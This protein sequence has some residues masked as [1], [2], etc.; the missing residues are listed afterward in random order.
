MPL[1]AWTLTVDDWRPGASAT[2]TAH[3]QRESTLDALAPWTRPPGRGGRLRHRPLLPHHGPPGRR[4]GP[5]TARRAARTGRRLRSR[6]PCASTA[7]TA[8]RRPAHPRAADLG[9]RLRPGTHT[10]E[11]EVATTLLNRLRVARPDV[12]GGAKR[13]DYGLT[14]PVRLVP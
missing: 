5:G 13:Q 14:G 4:L 3:E 6:S 8:A 11:I 7:T 2:E 10:I 1:T 9:A 12:F